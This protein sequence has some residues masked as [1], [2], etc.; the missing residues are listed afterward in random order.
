MYRVHGGKDR[1]ENRVL[2]HP[3]FL[4]M[5]SSVLKNAHNSV[6]INVKYPGTSS[7][8]VAESEC[9]QHTIDGLFICM[10]AGKDAVMATTESLATF[11]TA[12]E[13]SAMWP[14]TLHQ[15]KICLNGFAA[16]GTPQR[17]GRFH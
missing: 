4:T 8:A 17:Q 6:L 1:T 13:R 9:F 5:M 3:N 15:L 16:V 14:V 7:D 2:L 11:Q 12:V 10:K